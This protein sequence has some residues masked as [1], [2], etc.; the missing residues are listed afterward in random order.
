MLPDFCLFPL[1]GSRN[2]H[3][4]PELDSYPL[5]DARNKHSRKGGSFKRH[6]E[7]FVHRP[8]IRACV[9]FTPFPGIPWERNTEDPLPDLIALSDPN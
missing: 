8:P 4:G 3:K 9:Q 2:K 5:P 6:P 7:Q 1:A